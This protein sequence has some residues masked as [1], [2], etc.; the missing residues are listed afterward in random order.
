MNLDEELRAASVKRMQMEDAKQALQAALE[1]LARVKQERDE[2][3]GIEARQGDIIAK[4]GEVALN[5]ITELEQERPGLAAA[6]E[7]KEL[8]EWAISHGLS[9][10]EREVG[11]VA[12]NSIES[13]RAAKEA[14]DGTKRKEDQ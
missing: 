7:A 2:L 4:T 11:N 3:K 14:S 12:V 1:D 9:Y 10:W 5:R 8:L 6:L 13:L